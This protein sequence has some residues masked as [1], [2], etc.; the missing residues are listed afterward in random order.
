M[1]KPHARASLTFGILILATGISGCGAL[2][3]ILDDW[4]SKHPPSGTACASSAS[5][6]ADTHC[7][8][9]D[10]VCNAP[11][12]CKDGNVCPAVCYGTC[13]P[14]PGVPP[15]CRSDADC[16]AVSFMCTGCDCLALGPTEA[17]PMCPGQGVQCFADPC[18][19]KAAVCDAGQCRIKANACPAGS[20]SQRVCLQCGPAGGCAKVADCARPCKQNA[21]C[22]AEQTACS[23]GLCQMVGCI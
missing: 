21:D 12:G 4:H 15:E 5:C 3:D 16:R 18:L 8:V 13:E 20:V 11:P 1:S 9:E 2:D 10:G 19:N 17:E 22:A 14:K 23:E 6:P 7:T